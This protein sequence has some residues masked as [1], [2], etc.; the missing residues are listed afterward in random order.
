MGLVGPLLRSK[1]PEERTLYGLRTNETHK[2]AIGT[3]H[4]GVIT[5]F[6]D[7]VI[8]LAAW[9]AADRQP[10]VTIQMDTRFLSAAK[11][12]DFLKARAEIRQATGTLMFVDADVYC[13]EK[14][15]A[16]ATA[17]LKIIRHA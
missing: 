15:I 16:C 17:V 5:S 13:D 1:K 11:T 10:T 12:G 4:G 7:Q 14:S 6:L 9:N 8:A 2:N 3:V